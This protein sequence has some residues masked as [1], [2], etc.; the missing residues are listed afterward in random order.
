MII[1][2]FNL[3]DILMKSQRKSF[4]MLRFSGLSS[5]S[6]SIFSSCTDAVFTIATAS[7]ISFLWL[8][9]IIA[10]FSSILFLNRLF[11]DDLSL[12]GDWRRT[13]LLGACSWCIF[14]LSLSLTE[15]KIDRSWKIGIF[16]KWIFRLE[17]IVYIRV[18]FIERIRMISIVF[19]IISSSYAILNW[20]CQA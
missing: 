7:L 16:I 10:W 20:S 18:S 3:N 1:R 13:S 11:L 19:W 8:T 17:I 9:H 14:L 6:L 2:V 12:K 5:C 15:W 4:V